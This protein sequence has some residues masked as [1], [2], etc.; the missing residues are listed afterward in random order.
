VRYARDRAQRA[1]EL[2][3]QMVHDEETSR[4]KTGTRRCPFGCSCFG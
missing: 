3:N 1:V 2:D 4:K